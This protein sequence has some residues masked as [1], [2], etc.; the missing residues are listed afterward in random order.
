M[1]KMLMDMV[2]VTHPAITIVFL[3]LVGLV[4]WAYR[5]SIG[6]V[7]ALVLNTLFLKKFPMLA[8][9][10]KPKKETDLEKTESIKSG[11]R[12]NETHSYRYPERCL[13][14]NPEDLF[15]EVDRCIGHHRKLSQEC[16]FDFSKVRAMNVFC[17]DGLLK[18]FRK[19]IQENNIFITVV[20][21]RNIIDKID[22]AD[23][24][25]R[26]L[27]EKLVEEVKEK[28]TVTMGIVLDTRAAIS[29]KYD[30]TIV[31]LN[32]SDTRCKQDIMLRE[33]DRSDDC[34]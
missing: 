1:L 25:L 24:R 16:A 28:E 18:A 33:T 23:D 8:E 21:P 27:Y 17:K 14:S 15:V 31:S 19:A 29:L 13:V 32:P 34:G 2:T 6:P 7:V 20:F 5:E 30:L 26:F 11:L 4:L 12:V 3:L 22:T 10:A 9:M